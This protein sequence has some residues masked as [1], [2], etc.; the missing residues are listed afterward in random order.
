M[1]VQYDRYCLADPLFYD[2]PARAAG[3]DCRFSDADRILPEGWRRAYSDPWVNLMPA[4]VILPEQ[5]W[6]VHVSACADEAEGVLARV[7]DYCVANRLP[8]KFLRSQLM[9]AVQNSKYADRTGSGKFITVY[10]ETVIQLRKLLDELGPVLRGTSGPYI[11]SDLRWQ[12]GPLY[13][14]YGAF[15]PKPTLTTPDGRQVSDRRGTTFSVPDWAPVPDFIAEAIARRASD[16]DSFPFDVHRALH[17]S[18]GG[19]IYLAA[20]QRTGRKVV[21]REARPHAGIDRTGNDAVQRLHNERFVL[22]KLNGLDFVPELYE[23]IRVWEHHYLVVEYIEGETLERM[24][25]DRCPLTHPDPSADELVDYTEWVR[26]IVGQ[27]ETMLAEVHERGIV[28][29]DLQPTNIIVRPDG[30]CVLVDF[31]TSFEIGST[32]DPGL[33]TPGFSCPTART[34]T[35]IDHY[36]LA[37]IRMYLFAPFNHWLHLASAKAEEAADLIDT[38]Y[39]VESGF[40]AKIATAL[41]THAGGTLPAGAAGGAESRWPQAPASDT[42][43]WDNVL[44]SIGDGILAAATPERIDRLYPGDIEQ[45]GW[46][47]IGLG[48]AYGAAGVI[49]ALHA[50]GR[51]IPDEHLE[52]LVDKTRN[53]TDLGFGLYDGLAGIAWCLLKLQREEEAREFLARIPDRPFQ[54]DMQPNDRGVHSGAAGIALTFLQFGDH[55]RAIEIGTELAAPSMDDP[56]LVRRPPALPGLLNG[57]SGLAHLFH[58]LFDYTADSEWLEAAERALWL[59]LA[60][61]Q[62]DHGIPF[63]RSDKGNRMLP[64]LAEGTIGTALVVSEHLRYRAVPQF[65]DLLAGMRRLCRPRL[66]IAP[67][68]FEGRGSMIMYQALRREPTDQ[69][70]LDLSW[71]AMNYRGHIAFPGRMLLRLSTDLATGSAGILCALHSAVHAPIELPGIPFDLHGESCETAT[72]H[73]K[74]GE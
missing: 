7:I 29:A 19:G 31:E 36:A 16:K 42:A 28:L 39:P 72:K 65:S 45:F 10:P 15:A 35:A 44:D 54:C 61:I 25:V 38:F 5:G 74:G 53:A 51:R 21:L 6:K 58:R 55:Q 49:Y 41:H 13:L 2:D 3:D 18:N 73:S 59:D 14:R 71:H 11:L 32:A 37:A 9:L 63:L 17:F 68:L 22:A 1:D 33:A 48:L 26:D 24:F 52:W 47:R 27:L 46:G 40:G 56:H 70:L 60:G 57:P 67:G 23:H 20:D 66:T 50:C 34:G 43:V 62:T 12:G 64:Y 4:D 30:R 69:H 8:M